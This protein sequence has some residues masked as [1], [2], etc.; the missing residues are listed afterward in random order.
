MNKLNEWIIPQI[1]LAPDG[2]AGGDQNTQDDNHQNDHSDQPD[3]QEIELTDDTDLAQLDNDSIYQIMEL[4]NVQ[5]DKLTDWVR[6]GMKESLLFKDI[7]I[8]DDETDDKNNKN[9]AD[10]DDEKNQDKDPDY[11]TK[12]KNLN[13]DD[14]VKNNDGKE[15]QDDKTPVKPNAEPDKTD[16]VKTIKINDEYISNQIAKL[17]EQLKDKDPDLVNKQVSN[18]TSILNSIKDGEMDARTL[19]NYINAQT[20]IKTLKSPFDKDW[21]P[22]ARV[23]NTPEYIEKANKQKQQMIA[24]AIKEKYPDY[25]ESGDPEDIAE[26]EDSLTNRQFDE[27]KAIKKQRADEISDRYDRYQYLTENWEDIARDTV[28][29]EVQLFSEKLKSLKINQK[30]LGINTLD[31]DDKNYNEYL[32]KHIMFDEK[33]NPN[34]D[35]FLFVD[36]VIPI[37]KPFSVYNALMNINLDQIIALREIE[38]RKEAYKKGISDQPDPSLSDNQQNPG[39]RDEIDFN[40]DMFDDDISIDQHENMLSKIK[41]KILRERK[42]RI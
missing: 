41:N 23:V 26:W 19:K 16:S 31:L 34:P 40:E 25:P 22:D 3:D 21:K 14:S 2:A 29:S 8:A 38:A 1:L 39:Q 12:G 9:T 20:Y 42:N 28:K 13:D 17:K 11:K 36:N 35:V 33:G 27:Y 10:V 24:N 37:V 6:G 18:L 32:Y 15:K 5:I 30:D 7:K 4:D